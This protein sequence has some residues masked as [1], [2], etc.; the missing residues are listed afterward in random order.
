MKTTIFT[1]IG[2]L[3]VMSFVCGMLGMGLV[4]GQE[5]KKIVIPNGFKPINNYD[6]LSQLDKCP[7]HDCI[8]KLITKWEYSYTLQLINAGK[9]NNHNN[10]SARIIDIHES[11]GSATIGYTRAPLRTWVYKY[12][13]SKDVDEVKIQE[14]LRKIEASMDRIKQVSS[15]ALH[16]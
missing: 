14:Y 7:T 6:F 3:M 13:T 12:L 9:L 5:S 11:F 10:R 15:D 4:N 2:R 16:N 1:W 8:D